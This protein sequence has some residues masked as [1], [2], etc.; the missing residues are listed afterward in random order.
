MFA[1]LL[2]DTYGSRAD[3]PRQ[4]LDSTGPACSGRSRSRGRAELFA[5]F[6]TR[7]V[8]NLL[9][10]A[11]FMYPELNARGENG[12]VGGGSGGKQKTVGTKCRLL[13]HSFSALP[14]PFTCQSVQPCH[15]PEP[16]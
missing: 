14:P 2:K 13:L 9:C 7:V 6:W 4:A 15:S 11:L 10:L 12:A 16:R 5:S 1:Q 8:S 3:M